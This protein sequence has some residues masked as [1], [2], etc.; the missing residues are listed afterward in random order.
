MVKK[1]ERSEFILKATK[2]ILLIISLII[3]IFIA[4]AASATENQLQDGFYEVDIK[5]MHAEKDR[6]S[7]GSKGLS[8]KAFL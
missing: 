5:L 8:D 7:M 6:P 4:A 1:D 2:L 3:V